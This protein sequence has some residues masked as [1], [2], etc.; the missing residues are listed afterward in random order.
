MVTPIIIGGG[1]EKMMTCMLES[2]KKNF[3]LKG[4]K[5]KYAGN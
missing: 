5:K 3:Q 4:Q 2:E 1:E